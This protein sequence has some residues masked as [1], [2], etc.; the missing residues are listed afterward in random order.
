MP[1]FQSEGQ[2]LGGRWPRP[3]MGILEG[4]TRVGSHRTSTRAARQARLPGESLAPGRGPVGSSGA[5]YCAGLNAA[6]NSSFVSTP[7]WL[8]S[9]ASKLAATVG[10]A[11]ASALVNFPV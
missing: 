10:C 2:G 8:V 4:N 5:L 11:C 7:S 3:T 9:A 1:I 6:R